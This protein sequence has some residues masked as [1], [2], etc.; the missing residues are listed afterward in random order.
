MKKNRNLILIILV[1]TLAFGAGLLWRWVQGTPYY[2]LYQIGAGLKN[3]DLNTFLTYVDVESILNQQGSGIVSNLLSTLTVPAPSGKIT[4]PLGE[5]KIQLTPETN[6]GLSKL[7][8]QQLQKYL[9]DPKN[10]TVPSSFMLLARADFKVKQ[11]Y[12]LVTLKKDKDQLRMGM[13]KQGGLWRVK[14]L[15][16]EDTQQLIK[17]YLLPSRK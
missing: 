10:S 15:N 9:E 13:R 8:V 14:E 16:P 2:A 4:S 17:T 1:I 7:A 12:A 5:I 6:K 11:D 3:W